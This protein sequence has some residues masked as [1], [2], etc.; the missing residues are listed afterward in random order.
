[1]MRIET[2]RNCKGF[3]YLNVDNLSFANL[4]L[5]ENLIVKLQK[6]S[7]DNN[8]WLKV[9]SDVLLLQQSE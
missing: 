7:G 4:R 5:C 2:I 6:S 1:M 8:K 9:S 3:L